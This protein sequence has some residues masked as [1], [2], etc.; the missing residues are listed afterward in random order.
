MN[1]SKFIQLTLCDNSKVYIRAK[2]IVL[3]EKGLISGTCLYTVND[4]KSI[5]VKESID[6]ILAKIEDAEE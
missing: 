1:K 2:A 6:E 5:K 4:N 3:L